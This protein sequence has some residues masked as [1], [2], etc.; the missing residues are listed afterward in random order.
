M[1]KLLLIA[2]LA[3]TGCSSA[4]KGE[5]YTVKIFEDGVITLPEYASMNMW[6]QA[7]FEN[8][9]N[10]PAN[11]AAIAKIQGTVLPTINQIKVST[12]VTTKVVVK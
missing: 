4:P 11:Q 10:S 3:A 2:L 9:F 1:K 7:K 12:K 5:H 6:D 8:L